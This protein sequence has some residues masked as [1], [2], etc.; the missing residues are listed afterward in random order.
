MRSWRFFDG[1]STK[2]WSWQL[3]DDDT[4]SVIAQSTRQFP[5]LHACVK[6]AVAHGYVVSKCAT[7]CPQA[8]V[9]G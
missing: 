6:D 8:G 5:T 1:V 2:T 3:V 4:G 9:S 7:A